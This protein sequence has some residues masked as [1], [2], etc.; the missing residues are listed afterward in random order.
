[1]YGYLTR[2]LLLALPT[3]IGAT[4]IVFIIMRVAPGDVVDVIVGDGDVPEEQREEIRDKL[5]L[6]DP[7]PIQYLNWLGG[8]VTFDVGDSLVT[9][10][11]IVPDLRGRAFVTAELA[12]GSILLSLLIAIPLG[13]LSALKQDTPIDY[14]LRFLSIGGLSLPSFWI[15]TV[16]LVFLS[17]SFGWIPPIEYEEITEDPVQNLQQLFLPM[18][19]LG[20]ALSA[21]ISRLT[22]SSVLEVLREDYVR[23]ARAKGLRDRTVVI[24]HG[25]RNALLPVVTVT[26]SQ[27]GYLLGG[28]VI[29]ESIFTIPGVGQYTLDAI[30][31]R[32]YPV[33]QF[34]IVFM[35]T[36]QIFTN[37][38][39]DVSYGVIDPRIR[40]R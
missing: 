10:R 15:A 8:V 27:F 12:F 33:V 40:Y 23:T 28:T 35:A 13:T 2:R 3:L 19:I 31:R 22:R 37:L 32:D 17:R 14:A 39:T 9:D 6:H 38:L 29:M 36:I 21:V 16:L 25:L 18:L 7:V 20:Y 1:L 30:L 5:G 4:V 34:C 11:P 24:R 26:G